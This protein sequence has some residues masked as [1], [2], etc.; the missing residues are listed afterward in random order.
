MGPGMDTIFRD[1]SHAG[2]FRHAGEAALIARQAAAC[3]LQVHV[4]DLAA[5]HDKAGFLA[6]IGAALRMPAGFTSNWDAFADAL[7]DLS[8]TDAPGWMVILKGVMPFA[9]ASPAEFSVALE[10]CG[11]AAAFWRGDGRPFWVLVMGADGAA[12]TWP[13]LPAA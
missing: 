10:I 8:W 6:S 5:V 12:G 1:A 7:R 2:V 13:L 3:G 11:E 9:S 4:V